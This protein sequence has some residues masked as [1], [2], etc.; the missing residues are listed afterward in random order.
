MIYLMAA[1]GSM[2]LWI[3]LICARGGYWTTSVRDDTA[4]QPPA[5]WPG[6]AV[7]M[8]AR[9]EAETISTSVTSLLG[10]DYRG[11]L[12][13]I[14]VDDESDDGTVAVVERLA[15]SAPANVT[16]AVLSSQ[17][18]PPGWT[19]KLW[20]LK[21]GV[22]EVEASAFQPQFLLLTDADIVHAP[23]TLSWLV[24]HA[25]RDDLVQAS[26]MAKLR[27]RTLAERIHVPAFVY[28]F[29]ML[30][31]FDWVNNVRNPTA[32]AAGGCNLVR[33]DTLRKVGGIDAIRNS[34]IDDCSLAGK[35]KQHGPIWLGLSER[36][37]SLRPYKTL[38]EASQLASR[39]AYAQLRYSPWVVA[40]TIAAMA[41][42]FLA[43]PLLALFADGPA[44][45]LALSAWLAMNASFQP[46]LRFYRLSPMWGVALPIIAFLYTAYT[47][48]SAYKH[49]RR[50]GGQ[51]KGR[52]YGNV[53]SL[54]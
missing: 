18:L 15:D 37:R 23:D 48:E 13:M 12:S 25:I 6:V 24:A 50:R 16:L 54:R 26:F 28:F 52:V 44:R 42:V 32:A 10:Q 53:P 47:L 2:L 14:I 5:Q 45:W 19:G 38:A 8:P 40:G 49:A 34:L 11:P 20:A 39:S 17:G 51:W 46:I 43:P 35:L 36:V 3:Y 22:T 21:Q 7:V 27:C 4:P 30:Y 31:P 29:Q 33:F 41:L 9:N 1:C